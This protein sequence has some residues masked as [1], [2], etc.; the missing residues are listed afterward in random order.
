MISTDRDVAADFGQKG[1]REY[2]LCESCEDKTG[3]WDHYA[4]QVFYRKQ[5]RQPEMGNRRFRFPEVS[6]KEFKL[7]LMSLLWRMHSAEGALFN[8]ID[9][10][11][12]HSE[13]V[14]N[15]L[16]IDDPLSQDDYPCFITAVMIDGQFCE[17][18]LFQPEATRTDGRRWYHLLVAGY[19][20][21]YVV[22]SHPLPKGLTEH[23][24]NSNDELAV[25]FRE[26][27]EI[28]FLH[29]TMSG[30]GEAERARSSHKQ[31]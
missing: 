2:L 31:T 13:R 15:A 18:W 8:N 10:G 14:R 22:A 28:P 12:K 21:S 30:F 17:D 3:R 5:H 1:Y 24:L 23:S 29:K 25:Q 9:L 11:Q 16:L 26:L 20:F 6:Y 7:F 4:S 27:R 19:L